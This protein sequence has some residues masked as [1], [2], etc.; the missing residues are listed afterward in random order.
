ME[1]TICDLQSGRHHL[2]K[3]GNASTN[4]LRFS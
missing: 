3:T 2:T 4:R 1:V